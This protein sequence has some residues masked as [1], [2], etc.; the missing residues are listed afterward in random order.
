MNITLK[1]RTEE[2]V[3]TFWNKTRDEEIQRMFPSGT[4]TLDE[5]LSLFRQ[6]L[7]DDAT[8]YGKV[9]YYNKNYV[10]DVWCYAIDEAVKN[11]A[12]LSIVIFEKKYWGKGIA[13]A[14]IRM[15]VEDVFSKYDLDTIGAFTFKDN[16]RS[17]SLLRKVGFIEAETFTE[18]IRKTAY[19]ELQSLVK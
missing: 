7:S 9:I 14:A 15:F 1:T 6:S 2:H 16:N 17:L 4:E 8:S 10:G 13:T 19:L 3:L 11:Q 12:M 18:G 5:A